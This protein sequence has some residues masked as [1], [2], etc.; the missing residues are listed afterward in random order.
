VTQPAGPKRTTR[1]SPAPIIVGAIVIAFAVQAAVSAVGGDDSSEGTG[2]LNTTTTEI[3]AEP[4]AAT[5]TTVV[6]GPCPNPA[7]SD[8]ASYAPGP[9]PGAANLAAIRE[10]ERLIVG[11]S[12]DTLLFGARNPETGELEGFDI[13]I[14]KEVA[15]GIFGDAAPGRLEY[16]VINYADRLPNLEN[17]TVD[18]V[19][20]T[21]TINCERWK[22]INF[23]S[24]YFRAGQKILLR[25]DLVDAGVDSVSELTGQKVCAPD[26][27]TNIEEIRKHPNVETVA[28]PDLTDC[29]VLFQQGQV[30]GI[31]GDDTVLAGFAA[32]DPYGKVV[33]AAFSEEPYGI[34]VKKDQVD[35]VRFVNSVLE[36]IR[37]DGTW[38]SISRRWLGDLAP[39]APPQAVYGR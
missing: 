17:G 31:T 28:A 35:L 25:S 27:S 5:T 38:T 3:A 4:D 19:A 20:H 37:A 26:G 16:K 10:R 14:L 21:M 1:R 32:Q 8:V 39:P 23:S 11:V 6:P 34:G 22:R 36:R 2:A 13:D 30:D 18:L 29:L 33:G 24:E 9:N 15:R 7:V 12:A